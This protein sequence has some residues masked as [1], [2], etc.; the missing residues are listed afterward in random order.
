MLTTDCTA[1]L[2]STILDDRPITQLQPG[3][4]KA[5]GMKKVRYGQKER[6][7]RGGYTEGMVRGRFTVVL[8]RY[9]NKNGE[10]EIFLFKSSLCHKTNAVH[11][12]ND[13]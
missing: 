13:S 9:G 6:D 4:A 7:G 5:E 8:K 2:C 11:F 10:L 3:K 12:Q 1:S